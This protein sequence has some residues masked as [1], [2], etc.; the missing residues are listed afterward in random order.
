LE[1]SFAVVSFQLS[2]GISLLQ[3]QA[4]TQMSLLQLQANTQQFA[5][6]PV[7]SKVQRFSCSQ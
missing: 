2:T 7:L 3:L 6:L 1:W 5:L 4:K